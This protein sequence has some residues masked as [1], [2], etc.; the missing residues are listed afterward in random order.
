[1]DAAG[2]VPHRS[3]TQGAASDTAAHASVPRLSFFF[4][5]DSHRLGSIRVNSASIR[6]DSAKIGPYRPETETT[7]TAKTSRNRP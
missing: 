2:R 5:S 4:S 1:M 6:A 3:P 7:K